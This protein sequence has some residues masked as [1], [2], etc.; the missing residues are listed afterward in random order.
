MTPDAELADVIII[1]KV[2]RPDADPERV[3]DEVLELLME[4]EATDEQLD[5]PF[6]Y[7]SARD[8]HASLDPDVRGIDMAPLERTAT[9]TSRVP[10]NSESL[11][12]SLNT[13]SLMIAGTSAFSIKSMV[14][15]LASTLF[16]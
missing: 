10:D 1:N 11:W 3:H 9:G 6:L 13:S 16:S 5:A 2:D 7:A 14:N 15:L 4:L 8:G 12:Y